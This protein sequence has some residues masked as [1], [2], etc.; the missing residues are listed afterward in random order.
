MLKVLTA[1]NAGFCFGVKNAVETALK[2]AGGG[3]CY[4][5][6]DLI[7]NGTVVS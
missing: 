5:L 4:M 1:H 7:H 6:G 2:S 3:E